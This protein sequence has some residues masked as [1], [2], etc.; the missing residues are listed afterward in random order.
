M[1][2]NYV[3]GRPLFDFDLTMLGPSGPVYTKLIF[4]ETIIVAI[5]LLIY[6]CTSKSYQ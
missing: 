6:M 2:C 5:Q 4:S 3:I 1:S